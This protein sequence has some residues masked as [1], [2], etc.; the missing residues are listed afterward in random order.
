MDLVALG[1]EHQQHRHAII[2][3]D[4]LILRGYRAHFF[5][6]ALAIPAMPPM[7]ADSQSIAARQSN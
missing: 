7:I 1:S 5:V 6:P 4:R 3:T 2:L